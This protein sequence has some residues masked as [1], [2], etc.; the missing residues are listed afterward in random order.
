MLNVA[1]FVM[2]SV[3]KVNVVKLR[4]IM[5]G[6]IILSVLAPLRLSAY[7]MRINSLLTEAECTNV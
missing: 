7:M 2:L 3:I 5:L 1:F 6:V 4:V